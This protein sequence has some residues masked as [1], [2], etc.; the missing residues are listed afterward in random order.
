MDI[1]RKNRKKINTMENLKKLNYVKSSD[2]KY[3]FLTN[4]MLS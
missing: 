3:F 2:V 4:N 1:D